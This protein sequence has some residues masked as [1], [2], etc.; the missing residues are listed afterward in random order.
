MEQEVKTKTCLVIT[1]VGDPGSAQRQRADKVWRHIIEP[2]ADKLGYE[3]DRADKW[4]EPHLITKAIINKVRSADLVIADLTDRN[5]NV[6]YELAVRDSARKPA[7]Q[8][9]AKGQLLPFDVKE[10]RTIFYD[11]ADWDSVPTVRKSLERFIKRTEEA[12]YEV[13]NPIS[14]AIDVSSYQE[15]QRS[16]QLPLQQHGEVMTKLAGIESELASVIRELRDPNRLTG[17]GLVGNLVLDY[18]TIG[19]TPTL[20]STSPYLGGAAGI[21]PTSFPIEMKDQVDKFRAP[22]ATTKGVGGLRQF[23]SDSRDSED[24]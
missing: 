19:G 15:Y 5:A 14:Q 20:V 17:V 23:D 22:P 12:D 9:M 16:E 13:E 4:Q 2:V 3:A 24:E 8:L 7:I 11:P 18:R 10:Q 1:A 6:F 21:Y